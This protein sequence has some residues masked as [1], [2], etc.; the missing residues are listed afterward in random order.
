M[1]VVRLHPSNNWQSLPIIADRDNDR[2]DRFV[3]QQ[4]VQAESHRL[5]LFF[6]PP[7][8]SR[9]SEFDQCFKVSLVPQTA[10]VILIDEPGG[11][12]GDLH[13]SRTGAL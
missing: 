5:L 9:F 3:R 10:P 6:H 2:L 7:I 1:T 12:R 4:G 13:V 8:P 11:I